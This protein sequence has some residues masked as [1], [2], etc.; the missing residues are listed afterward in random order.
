LLNLW[1]VGERLF[2]NIVFKETLLNTAIRKFHP[3]NTM[4]D[5]FAP[6]TFVAAAIN[7][8][9]LSVTMPFVVLVAPPI[10]VA[11]LPVKRANSAFFIVLVFTIVPVAI[12]LLASLPPFPLAVLQSMLE[13]TCILALILPLVL[14]EAMRFTELI[15]ASVN[16]THSKDIAAL[17][18]L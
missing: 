6:F 5:A 18:V 2:E 9:H 15:L 17:S 13:F 1:G 7:P 8:S 12:G 10:L 11:T 14:A 4:L 3:A 16:V